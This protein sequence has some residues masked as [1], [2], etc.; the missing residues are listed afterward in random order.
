M[1]VVTSY[2]TTGAGTEVHTDILP[3]EDF[4]RARFSKKG[5]VS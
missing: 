3:S 4:K 1:I 2:I 5:G